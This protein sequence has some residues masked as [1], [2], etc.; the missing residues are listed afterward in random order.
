MPWGLP[1]FEFVNYW[2]EYWYLFYSIVAEVW[3]L[4][5]LVAIGVAYYYWLFKKRVKFAGAIEFIFLAVSVPENNE[6]NPKSMEEIFAGY[7]AIKSSPNLKEIYL[8]GEFQEW[9]SFEIVSIGGRIRYILRIPEHSRD[10]MKAN[11]YAQYP[12]AEIEEV[13]DDYAQFVPEKYPNDEYDVLGVEFHLG[14]EDAYPIRTYKYYMDDI[15]EEQFID[16]LSNLLEVM[17]RLAE[18]EQIWYQIVMEPVGPGW[19]KKGDK[20][21]AKL[22]KRKKE[23]YEPKLS[24]RAHQVTKAIGP[25]VP[26]SDVRKKDEPP[27]QMLHLSPGE[28]EIVKAVEENISKLGYK[29]KVRAVYVGKKDVFNKRRI[30][31]ALMGAFKAFGTQNLNTLRPHKR[32]WTFVSY[33]KR[34]RRPVRQ[35]N[36]INR[37]KRRSLKSGA[38][39][40]VLNIEELATIY[41]FPYISVKSPSMVYAESGKG[42]PPTDLPVE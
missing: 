39:P 13:E 2:Y 34:T 33:F 30:G 40:V 18:G 1:K 35:T 25:I 14:K 32:Y 29:T 7:H 8:L 24:N 15:S 17:S 4:A 23:E 26:E 22:I 12:E 19:K 28:Q 37:Y 5:I 16:P 6:R 3:W 27:T 20:L 21:V 10:F 36:L 11:V 38:H 42:L 9:F 31:F 41:H